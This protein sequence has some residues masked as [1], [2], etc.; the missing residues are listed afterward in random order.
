MDEHTA[1]DE[2]NGMSV[3]FDSLFE[4]GEGLAEAFGLVRGTDE[5]AEPEEAVVIS[6]EVAPEPAIGTILFALLTH[7]LKVMAW[8]VLISVGPSAIANKKL[9]KCNP[10]P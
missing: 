5:T 1:E 7:F 8:S 3:T 2:G 4:K 6:G 10:S 9:L